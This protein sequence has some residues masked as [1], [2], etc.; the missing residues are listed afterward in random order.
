RWSKSYTH[1]WCDMQDW[2]IQRQLWCGHRVPV[3]RHKFLRADLRRS[4]RLGESFWPVDQVAWMLENAQLRDRLAAG[5]S[6]LSEKQAPAQPEARH[7]WQ[8]VAEDSDSVEIEAVTES[9]IA[10]EY[11]VKQGFTQD[12][13]VLDTWA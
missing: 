10:A 5:E 12:P 8:V 2:C 6:G 1:C 9:D 7:W 13:D 3:C 11:L 4:P